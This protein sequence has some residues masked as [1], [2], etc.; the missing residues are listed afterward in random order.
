MAKPKKKFKVKKNN[1]VHTPEMIRFSGKLS[2]LIRRQ[3]GRV[4]TEELDA[5]AVGCLSTVYVELSL[6]NLRRSL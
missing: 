1:F 6:E 5:F 2:R 3:I 4:S